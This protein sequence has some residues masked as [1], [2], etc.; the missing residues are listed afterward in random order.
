VLDGCKPGG[1]AALA[2]TSC[3]FMDDFSRVTVTRQSPSA[4]DQLGDEPAAAAAATTEKPGDSTASTPTDQL[5]TGSGD[6]MVKLSNN[7]T[8]EDKVSIAG[9]VSLKVNIEYVYVCV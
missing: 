5:S 4:T 9:A 8:V 1:L 7:D 2:M 6:D 3:D